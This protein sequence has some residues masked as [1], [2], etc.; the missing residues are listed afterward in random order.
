MVTGGGSAA[1]TSGNL[2]IQYK[3]AA[4]L[5]GT[6]L[7]TSTYVGT[8]S[9][10][11]TL[12]WTNT[13]ATGTIIMQARSANNAAMSGASAWNGTSSCVIAASGNTLASGGCMNVGDSYV[14]Y[15]ATLISLSP[16]ATPILGSVNISYN[17]SLSSNSNTIQGSGF[18]LGTFVNATTTCAEVAVT[19]FTQ[20]ALET[21]RHIILF[22]F[23]SEEL[24]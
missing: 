22:P 20:P 6:Y 15:Q 13:S 9:S 11:G 24:V 19:G 17:Q 3:T 5:S 12:S 7:S 8:V 21:M 23:T 14:Q 10:W 2:S 18:N 4:P 16:T 1:G